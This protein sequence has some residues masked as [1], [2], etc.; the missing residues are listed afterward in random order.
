[1]PL[2]VAEIVSKEYYVNMARAW[3][4]Q[5]AITKQKEAILPYIAEQKLDKWTHNKTIQKCIESYRISD[6]DKKLL[7]EMKL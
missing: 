1:M 3:F 2:L 7:K 5:T 4:F 6:D